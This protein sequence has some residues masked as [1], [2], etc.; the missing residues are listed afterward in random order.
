MAHSKILFQQQLLFRLYNILKN[1]DNILK[2]DIESLFNLE[3]CSTTLLQ[4][5]EELNAFHLV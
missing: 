4:K 5:A 1:I 2:S 3:L